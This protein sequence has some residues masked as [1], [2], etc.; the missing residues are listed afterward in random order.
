MLICSNQHSC[1]LLC[2]DQYLFVR[3]EVVGECFLC[4]QRVEKTQVVKFRLLNHIRVT[5]DRLPKHSFIAR[6]GEGG[7]NKEQKQELV[8]ALMQEKA[9]NEW[10]L[11]QLI[12]EEKTSKRLLE[13]VHGEGKA[14]FEAD[15]KYAQLRLKVEPSEQQ[16]QQ[17]EMERNE[18]LAMNKEKDRVN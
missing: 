11:N 15:D 7:L 3:G 13:M 14:G 1:C 18:L 9:K 17:L 2:L 10:L 6:E 16:I 5:I 8:E 4:K 12:R